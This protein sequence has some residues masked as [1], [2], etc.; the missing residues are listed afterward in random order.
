M[1][2]MQLISLDGSFL[3]EPHIP[4]DPPFC[5]EKDNHSFSQRAEVFGDISLSHEVSNLDFKTREFYTSHRIQNPA[6][7]IPREAMN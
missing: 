5:S 7:D 3:K 1:E 6:P 2:T 4:R